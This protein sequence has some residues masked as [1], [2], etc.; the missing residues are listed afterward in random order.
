MLTQWDRQIE[1]K[2]YLKIENSYPTSTVNFDRKQFLDY[3]IKWGKSIFGWKKECVRASSVRANSCGNRS[4]KHMHADAVHMGVAALTTPTKN[5]ISVFLGANKRHNKNNSQPDAGGMGS[6]PSQIRKKDPTAL[7]LQVKMFKHGVRRPP[8]LGASCPQSES[9]SVWRHGKKREQITTPSKTSAGKTFL[10]LPRSV[11]GNTHW[12][13]WMDLCRFASSSCLSIRR[14]FWVTNSFWT[15][16]DAS[17]TFWDCSKWYTF[18]MSEKKNECKINFKPAA[19]FRFFFSKCLT[20]NTT[21]LRTSDP[22]GIYLTEFVLHVWWSPRVPGGLHFRLCD[23]FLKQ[24][25]K[26]HGSVDKFRDWNQE[27]CTKQAS[28]G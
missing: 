24:K 18:Q 12:K 4:S 1:Q 17:S 11:G 25:W 22:S 5:P 8:R 20:S 26:F 10:P 14:I 19:Q 16:A 28:G 7:F 21:I 13:R 15:F 3:F 6:G 2:K 27:V 9:P 23:D